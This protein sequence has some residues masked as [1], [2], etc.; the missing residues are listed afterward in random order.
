MLRAAAPTSALGRAHCVRV[1]QHAGDRDLC[2]RVLLLRSGEPP[3]LGD[4]PTVL[5][6]YV[7]ARGTTTDPRLK[8]L[9]RRLCLASTNEEL[10]A[11]VA[12]GERLAL[13][14]D[15]GIEAD[16][17]RCGVML[18]V[19]RS[20]GLTVFTG[21]STLDGDPELNLRSGDRLAARVSFSANMLRG[22]YALNVQLV[23]GLR[24]W[25]F[26]PINNVH[27]FVVT[28]TTRISGVAELSP[29][30]EITVKEPQR[31]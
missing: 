21:L 4:M 26:A 17:P 15:L 23:D 19:M 27:S 1:A 16:L 12:P 25:P 20:D 29:S 22:T 24:Q 11:P 3:L 14:I 8:L 2:D 30:Y 9:G 6:E 18:Q 5:G 7:S 28:E 10:T 13:E 31:V